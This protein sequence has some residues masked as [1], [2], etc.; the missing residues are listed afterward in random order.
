MA[1]TVYVENID[2]KV[3]EADLRSFFSF[4]GRIS[5]I[6]ITPTSNEADAVKS[7]SVTF[8]QD[9]AAKTALLLDRSQLGPRQVRVSAAPTLDQLV[10]RSSP[11]PADAEIRQEDKPRT[12]ILAEYL[13]QGYVISDKVIEKGIALDQEHGF[14]KKFT[15]TL[16]EFDHKFHA[17]EKARAVDDKYSVTAKASTRWKDMQS[18]FE[19]A[20]DT[21]TGR[22][23]RKFYEETNKQVVDVH[24][25]AR[26]LADLKRSKEQPAKPPCE[27]GSPSAAGAA[28]DSTPAPVSD[29]E[30]SGLHKVAGSDRTQ[31]NCAA[32]SAACPC[33]AGECA[34][35]GCAKNP[36]AAAAS[37]TAA[38]S[39]AAA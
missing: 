17:T 4:C 21:P 31:C 22:K 36:D 33:P 39:A 5:T 28:T 38:S 15:R 1:V 8:E 16:T 24:N 3:S 12:R 29:I 7:A 23:L 14:S 35:A 19:K 26:H 2:A 27:C 37:N 34:C 13:A 6:S 18:Y 9:A 30:K 11:E 20:L 32:V 25:E 10:S